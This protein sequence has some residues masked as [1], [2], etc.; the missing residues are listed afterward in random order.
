MKKNTLLSLMFFA[1]LYVNMLQ[2]QVNIG[3]VPMSFNYEVAKVLEPLI[4]DQM[5]P[6]DMALIEIEDAQWEAELAANHMKLGRRFGIEFEV[7][8]DLHNSGVWINL[9]DGGKLWRLGIECPGA[10]SINLIFDQY[11]LPKGATVYIFAENKSDKIGGFTDYNN[12]ADNFFATDIVL[13]DK[14]VI[15]Y[16]QPVNANFDGELRLATIVHGYRGSSAYPKGF[17]QSG[18]CQRNTICPEGEAWGDQI[19][20]VFALY[21]GG[22][23]VCSGAILNNTAND[24]TPYAFTANHCWN[25][26]QNTG[27]WVFRFNWESPTCTPTANSSYKTMSG[28]VLRMRTPT[29]T[30]S[31]DACLVEL[32]QPIPEDYGVFYAG[33][34]RSTTAPTSGMIIHHPALDIKKITPSTNIYAVTQY[35][36]GWRANFTVGGPCT[37][38]GSSGSPLFDQNGRVI[39]SEYGGKS[40]C[41]APAVDMFDVW[42]RFDVS[43]NGSA[44]ANRLRDWLDPLGLDPETWDGTY[45][46]LATI[47][48]EMLE[49]I[50]PEE[51]YNYAATIE[52][53]VKIKNS[54]DATINSATISYTINGGNPVTKPWTGTLNAGATVDIIFDAITLTSGTHVFKATVTVENDVNPDNDS[55]TKEFKV[56]IEPALCEMPVNLEGIVETDEVICDAILTWNQP[57]VIDGELLGYNIYRDGV[58][59]NEAPLTDTQYIDEGIEDGNYT[60]QVSAVYEHCEE[61]PLT[62]GFELDVVCFVGVREIASDAFQI[63]PN[64][65]NNS[66]IIKG[67]GLNR[68][69]LYD[70]QGRKLIEYNNINDNLQINVNQYENGVYF[71]KMYSG[72]HQVTKR[73]M[74][75]K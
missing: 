40:Y 56:I 55:K 48:A 31:T 50:V 67:E 45:T 10:L 63:F 6:L 14:I 46:T 51:F 60:Y 12:Q 30:S 17:G 39:G 8:Y 24:K 28:A 26:Y 66:V 69:E 5:P 4:F 27:I 65:A 9:P 22:T 72:T 34:S 59:L 53:K 70:L 47:D 71:V 43:W 42:G 21:S 18:S 13:S 7:D 19:R 49:I 38:G 15:E 57:A 52:P 2:A 23:E 11:R 68:V 74:I 58:Q 73:L 35:V 61:S 32:N 41:G 16:Y 20:S 37:E 36:Q 25:Y 62:E 29:N 75:V 33:W 44:A 64:P 1:F 3:G 54:G